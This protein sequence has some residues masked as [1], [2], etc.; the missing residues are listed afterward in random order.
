MPPT[1]PSTP[2]TLP[3]PRPPVQVLPRFGIVMA[4]MLALAALPQSAL[5]AVRQVEVMGARA[6]NPAQVAAIAGVQPG[7]RLFALDAQQ[8]VRRLLADPRIR[9]A[10]VRVRPPHTV[11]LAI[12]ERIPVVAVQAGDAGDRR[13]LL[14]GDD[15]IVVGDA[16]QPSGLP[17]VIDRTGVGPPAARPGTVLA[18]GAV[19]QAVA[20]LPR[21]PAPLRAGLLW[22]GVGSGRDLT[23]GLASGLVIRAGGQAALAERLA[24]VPAILDGLRARGLRPAVL[25]LRYAGSIAVT[26]HADDPAPAGAPETP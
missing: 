18:T 6:L 21:V 22:I 2:S 14:V 19:R 23:L 15:L 24:Q 17:V 7:E 1:D 16:P 8:A 10:D 20:A 12:V 25:D 5:F 13:Y 11:A 3:S 9:A 26:L 4:A